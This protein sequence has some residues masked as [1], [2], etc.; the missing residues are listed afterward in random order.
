MVSGGDK[1]NPFACLKTQSG[2]GVNKK[3]SRQRKGMLGKTRLGKKV[4][5]G[6]KRK[7]GDIRVV[8]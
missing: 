8:F 6:L 5:M 1:C 2:H 3:G 4:E 7:E